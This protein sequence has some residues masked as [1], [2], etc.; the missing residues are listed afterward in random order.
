ML[1]EQKGHSAAAELLRSWPE[2]DNNTSTSANTGSVSSLQALVKKKLHPRRSIDNLALKLSHTSSN[3]HLPNL[4]FPISHNSSSPN[5]SSAPAHSTLFTNTRRSSISSDSA[6]NRR[7]SLPSVFERAIHHTKS[8]SGAS[9]RPSLHSSDSKTSIA[10]SFWSVGGEKMDTQVDS[11]SMEMLRRRSEDFYVGGSGGGEGGQQQPTTAPPM[12][13]SF[14]TSEISYPQAS[15]VPTRSQSVS[16]LAPAKQS[17]Y[18]IPTTS[19]TTPAQ[20]FYRP[21][22]SSQ[23]SGRSQLFQRSLFVGGAE[24]ECTAGAVFDEREVSPSPAATNEVEEETPT[25]STS[26]TRPR[27]S[28]HPHERESSA[29]SSAFSSVGGSSRPSS[30]EGGERSRHFVRIAEPLPY[31]RD[32]TDSV[33][34][35]TSST[36]S[37]RRAGGGGFTKPSS[38]LYRSHSSDLR[39]GGIET[40]SHRS[41]SGATDATASSYS[42]LGVGSNYAPSSSTVASSVAPSSPQHYQPQPPTTSSSTSSRLPLLSPLYEVGATATVK[43]TSSSTEIG[44]AIPRNTSSPILT[45]AQARSR[46][47]QAEQQLLLYKPSDVSSD[48]TGSRL[49]LS[50]QLAA[51]GQNLSLERKLKASEEAKSKV[52]GDVTGAAYQWETIG[53]DGKRVVTPVTAGEK[54]AK[55][56][57]SSNSKLENGSTKGTFF[58]LLLSSIPKSNYRPS[59]TVQ[60]TPSPVATPSPFSAKTPINHKSSTEDSKLFSVPHWRAIPTQDRLMPPATPR[61]RSVSPSSNHTSSSTTLLATPSKRS[62]KD[63]PPIS[64]PSERES[65]SAGPT[66]ASSPSSLASGSGGISYVEVIPSNSGNNSSPRTTTKK[67]PRS[68]RTHSQKGSVTSKDQILLDAAEQ[69]RILASV[70]VAPI[71]VLPSKKMGFARRL[72]SGGKS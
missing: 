72:F 27:I 66:R 9:E 56:G 45:S 32:R 16:A 1:A 44:Q 42:G 68:D 7:P 10:S 29:A 37:S 28:S 64:I 46:V 51:Y 50:Q 21:R 41:N 30:P 55:I 6:S 23:L 38:S 22:Q 33:G 25:L 14:T 15:T 11:S 61:G 24:K 31:L 52:S 39:P 3:P 12:K 69:A 40:R 2:D 60:S 17:T 36:F 58:F 43:S 5:L 70:P 8:G 19:T 13:T 57:S 53:K 26:S 62:S 59:A 20:N 65:R 35:N 71:T 49:S 63:T 34:S 4:H 54:T 47:K 67:G 18:P 48:G